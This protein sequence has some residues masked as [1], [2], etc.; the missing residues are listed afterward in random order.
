MYQLIDSKNRVC[1]RH[2]SKQLLEYYAEHVWFMAGYSIE[3]L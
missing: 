1:L 2:D 3:E